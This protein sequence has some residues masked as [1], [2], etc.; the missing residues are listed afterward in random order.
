MNIRTSAMQTVSCKAKNTIPIYGKSLY[1]RSKMRVVIISLAFVFSAVDVYCQKLKLDSLVNYSY[2]INGKNSK[3]F[4]SSGTASIARY[5][6]KF[7]LI[8]NFHVLTGK[9]YKTNKKFPELK[10]TNTAVSIIFQPL[11]RKSEFQVIIYPL[12]NLH[13]EANFETCMFQ[14]QIIDIS[15]MPI[16]LPKN[17]SKFFFE[18]ND[19]DTSESYESNQKL[20]AFGFPNGKFKNEWQPT[21]LDV[22][23]V[24]N[25][26][27]GPFIYDPFVF[28][29]DAPIKGM[30][31]SPVYTTDSKGQ[32]KLL[33][34]VS[35]VVDY[36]KNNP[37]IK[38]RSI[39]SSLALRLIKKMYS[40]KR[41]TVGGEVY[42][43]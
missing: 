16:D 15:V 34:I 23:A 43:R 1:T 12:F 24:K 41:H 5:E 27:A 37:T 2:I 33:A 18:V 36:D 39:Y 6:N 14:K 30:S 38:G 26:E 13:N 28:L 31:G 4:L 35:N 7:F 9:D 42:K 3:E 21:Q 17:A 22:S 25:K 20:M 10:D 40:E 11:D 32:I 29:D 19:F 8:T